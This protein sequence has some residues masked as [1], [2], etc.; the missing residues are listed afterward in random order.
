MMSEEPTA[1]GLPPD[2]PGLCVAI[3]GHAPLPIATVDGAT[4]ILRYANPAFCLLMDE[5]LE[6][7]V[8]RPLQDLLPA[9]DEC[10]TLLDRVFRTGRPERHIQKEDAKPHPV[11]WSYTI[12]PMEADGHHVGIMIQVTESGHFH[13]TAMAVNEAL[14][15][16]AVRQHQLTDAAEDVSARLR[17]EIAARAVITAELSQKARE[18]AEKA[19]L[20]DLTHDAII[21]RDME[22]RIR[23]WNHG[24]EDLYGWSREEAMGKVSHL[25][26]QTE[27]PVPVEQM[28]AELHRNDRWIGELVHTASDGRR[29]TVLAR[30]TLDRDG[31]GRPAAV[32]E[33]LTDITARKRAE[34][35]LQASQSL[36]SSLVE[37][38]PFGMYVVDDHFR[39]QQVN[40]RALPMLGNVVPLVG[41]DFTEVVTVLWGKEVGGRLADIFRHTLETGERYVSPPFTEQRRDLDVEESYEWEVQR[42]TL[43]D[44]HYAVVC[45]FADISERHALERSIADRAADLVRADR[46][47]DEFLGMLAHELRNPLAPLRSATEILQTPG[48]SVE[49]TGQA[50]EILSRQIE[51]MSEMIDDLLDVSRITEGK[52]ELRLEVVALEAVLDAAASLAERG[53]EARGQEITIK[54]PAEPVFLHA[55]ATRL[56][57]VFG[58]L[59]TNACKYSGPGCH[60]SVRAERAEPLGEEPPEVIV[61][62]RDNGIGI[63]PELLPRIFDLFVQANRSLDRAHGG[64]GIGLT[65]VQRLVKLHG[66]SVEARSE[67]LGH[68]SEFIVRLPILAA[69]AAPAPPPAAE[70]HNTPHRILIVDDNEDSAW[71]MATLQGMRGHETRT[72][73]TGPDAIV[74]AAEFVPD[75]VL[76][77]IGLPGMDGYEVARQLRAMPATAG[78]FLVA[79]TG[80]GRD[81]DRALTQEAGFDRHLVKPVDLDILRQLLRERP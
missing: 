57:Q 25:L 7:L 37:K 76:L 67:G 54:L 55:D 73:F 28:L 63:A 15:L 32:L 21:V 39:L 62:V 3:T 74:A 45:Y 60:I 34:Q 66:G 8:G 78:T 79:M 26:L 77:D 52:I 46:S 33:N 12:W 20:L 22:G 27:F 6:R 36:F 38:A 2:L 5:P 75:V 4:H 47:K 64:L 11:F 43:P 68:G 53:I 71:T 59:L 18:L 81:E 69:A 1:A 14:L 50:V 17:E 29:L 65:L 13:E 61:R 9:R 51:N 30:K 31:E 80:Y 70:A 44:G 19:R 56:D 16:G 24:A 23:Y 72:A 35:A 42:F 10:V 40:T 41:R 58:N 49:A 48:A